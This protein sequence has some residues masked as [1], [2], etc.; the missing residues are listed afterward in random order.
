MA[1]RPKA[2]ECNKRFSACKRPGWRNDGGISRRPGVG[3]SL[4]CNAL[5]PYRLQRVHR[6]DPKIIESP[7][8]RGRAGGEKERTSAGV[9]PRG[10]YGRNAMNTTAKAALRAY[11]GHL[12]SAALRRGAATRQARREERCLSIGRAAQRFDRSA[13]ERAPSKR[14]RRFDQCNPKGRGLL[15]RGFVERLA[16]RLGY[17]PR[18]SPARDAKSLRRSGSK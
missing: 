7:R 18:L 10:E 4:F 12:E 14:L 16:R 13:V 6:P 11:P 3:K 15:R 17:A 8:R 5:L 1:A 2:A 9:P